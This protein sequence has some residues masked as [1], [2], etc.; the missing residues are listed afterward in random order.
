LLVD[1]T[2]RQE[3]K[4]D[5]LEKGCDMKKAAWMVQMGLMA[6]GILMWVSSR[7]EVISDKILDYDFQ[8]V[9]GGVVKDMSGHGHNGTFQGG[10]TTLIDEHGPVFASQR[11]ESNCIGGCHANVE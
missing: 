1:A 5:E 4:K 6:L 11:N 3:S 8:Q 7:A 10:A 2:T 9:V